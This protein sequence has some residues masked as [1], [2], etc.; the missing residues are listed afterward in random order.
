MPS[1]FLKLFILSFLGGFEKINDT[2]IVQ[3]VHYRIS[4]KMQSRADTNCKQQG[5]FIISE[6]LK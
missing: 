2:M 5:H 1:N 3:Q 6:I 4:C